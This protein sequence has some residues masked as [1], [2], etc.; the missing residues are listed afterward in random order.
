MKAAFLDAFSGLSGDMIV[1]AMLDAG[2]DLDHLQRSLASLPLDGYRIS[3][4]RKVLSGIS[5]LKFDVEVAAR[6]PERHLRE[7]RE[8]IVRGKALSENVKDRAL[9]IFAVL[10]EAEA[11]VHRTSPEEVHFHEVGAVDSI[12]DIVAAA[13]GFER[14][15]LDEMIVSPL[16]AGSGT[17]RSQH[18]VI[19][20]PAPA[21]A[22]LLAGYPLRIGD[23]AAEMVTPT[24]AAIVR[25]LAKPAQPAMGFQIERVGYGAGT[26]KFADRPNVLRLML[27]ERARSWEADDLLQIETNIDDLNPQAYDH[28]L[29][30]LFEAGARDVTLTPTIM[31]KG[32]PGVTVAVLAE[33]AAREAIAAV[34]FAETS[35]IGLRY[36]PV[37]RLKLAR[38]FIDVETQWGPV[39][40]KR[41]G[42][43]GEM[44]TLSP[45]YD[46]CKRLAREHRV[47]L[48]TVIDEAREAARR[49]IFAND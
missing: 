44:L 24:G 28:V 35:T 42:A 25:A 2:A 41:S 5:A 22:E 4:S 45:E 17:V 30:R 10:A 47:A 20:V 33:P 46:D 32:R 49:R 14:L 38:E 43:D 31:K 29:E 3:T 27:G 15:D 36:F 16:P 21:T 18:G 34:L 11:K 9:A 1:G 39:R 40:V 7:I 8:I 26:K 23:G 12:I 19:P 48:R 37:A 13:W 6:Q